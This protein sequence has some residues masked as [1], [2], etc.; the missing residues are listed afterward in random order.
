[1]IRGRSRTFSSCWNFLRGS[2]GYVAD[3]V[4]AEMQESQVDRPA[5]CLGLRMFNSLET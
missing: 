2:D 1:M 3:E 4:R 5:A